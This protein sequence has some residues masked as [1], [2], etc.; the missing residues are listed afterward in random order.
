MRCAPSACASPRAYDGFRVRGIPTRPQGG[1][2]V[3]SGGDHRIAML[4]ALL[5]L[6]SR[7]GV[8]VR[9]TPMRRVSFPGFFDVLDSLRAG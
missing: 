4:G 9:G 8:D 2:V 6:V 7:E 1:G 3:E 5:G